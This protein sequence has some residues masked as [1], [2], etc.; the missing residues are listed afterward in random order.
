VPALLT[1]YPTA[2]QAPLAIHDTPCRVL[3]WAPVG[4]G[5][6]WIVQLLPF[7]TS[8]SV[9]AL[10]ALSR[11][12]PAAVQALLDVQDTPCRTLA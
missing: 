1:E 8:A 6:L 12:Y 9:K 7:Q 4:S 3:V 11:S 10:P 2:V 5:V